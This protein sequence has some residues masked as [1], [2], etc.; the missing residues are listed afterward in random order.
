MRLSRPL[1]LPDRGK[2]RCKAGGTSSATA[3]CGTQKVRSADTPRKS[4]NISRRAAHSM[5]ERGQ[6]RGGGRGGG[7]RGGGGRG[8]GRGGGAQGQ[9]GAGAGAERKKENIIDLNKYIDKE[10]TVKFSGGRE[11][12]HAR[13]VRNLDVK[14]LIRYAVV[15]GTLKGFDQLMN[16]VLDNVKEVTRGKSRELTI[17]GWCSDHISRRRGQHEHPRTGSSG[18]PRHVVGAHLTK[19]R[20]RGNREPILAGRRRRRVREEGVAGEMVMVS[21]RDVKVPRNLRR[22]SSTTSEVA[23]LAFASCLPAPHLDLTT[24]RFHRSRVYARR[25]MKTAIACQDQD[26]QGEH[27]D[28][29]MLYYTVRSG[30]AKVK[31]R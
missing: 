18:R 16:L 31:Q 10:L 21:S 26:V 25:H 4:V 15:V 23:D 20:Q 5:S 28:G 29:W 6:F 8:G 14:M 12:V 3:V 13:S 19:G 9:G 27:R 22:R 11:G 24:A 2:P 7:G 17:L 1:A 30:Q